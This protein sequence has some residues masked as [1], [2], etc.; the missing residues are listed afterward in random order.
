MTSSWLAPG[1]SW[2]DFKN[3]IFNLVLLISIFIF[4]NN[5]PRLISRDL[6]EYKYKSTLVQVMAW[7]HQATSH[8]LSQCWPRF[9]SP[10]DITRLQWINLWQF[11][12]LCP[13]DAIIYL[14]WHC[15]RLWLVACLAPSHY[16][17]T[18]VDLPNGLLSSNI[19]I[20]ENAFENI[21]YKMSAILSKHQH[22]SEKG[23]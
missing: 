9:M 6:T 19:F 12:K 14:N 8:Y 23:H 17:W 10:Y 4:S 20:Q 13:S 21:I 15:Y 3:A 11:N 2:C 7:W 22:L 16:V 5:T 18:N 1:R